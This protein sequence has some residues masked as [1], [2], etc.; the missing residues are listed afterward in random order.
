M[1][2]IKALCDQRKRQEKQLHEKKKKEDDN[3]D[4]ADDNTTMPIMITRNSWL[5]RFLG[6]YAKWA[7]KWFTL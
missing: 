6:I 4:N 7:K 3:D 5:N 1:W 2:N